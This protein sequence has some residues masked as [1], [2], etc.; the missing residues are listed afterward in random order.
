M[1]F[2]VV[3]INGLNSQVE[4]KV[5]PTTVYDDF[6]GLPSG[7]FSDLELV[8]AGL[9]ISRSPK[10]VIL[11]VIIQSELYFSFYMQRLHR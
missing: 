1:V 11:L 4:Q 5:V 6:P 7:C 8:S 2:Y 9:I 10:G 3:P